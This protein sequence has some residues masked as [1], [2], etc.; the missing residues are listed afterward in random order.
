MAGETS[1]V[2]FMPGIEFK[3]LLAGDRIRQTGAAAAIPRIPFNFI[4]A[5]IS[6]SKLE[7]THSASA[8]GSPRSSARPWQW[9]WAGV[10][11]WLGRSHDAK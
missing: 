5:T 3:M 11:Y 7:S 4:R 2:E 8:P 10:G 1:W 9:P 6:G